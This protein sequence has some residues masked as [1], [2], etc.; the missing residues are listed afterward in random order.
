VTDEKP[1]RRA[2][3]RSV[4]SPEWPA[5]LAAL[6]EALPFDVAARLHGLVPET[7]EDAL[8]HDD[9]AREAVA[10]AKAKGEAT[11][12]REKRALQKSGER[13]GGYEWD[14]ERLYPLRYRLPKQV[15]TSGPNGGAQVV[16]H[17]ITLADANELAKE[18]KR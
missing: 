11:M 13:T 1:H 14:L 6:E 10:A 16:R 4:D 5:F 18:P 7:I 15:E 3:A 2:R 9:D 17:E 12:L 8:K